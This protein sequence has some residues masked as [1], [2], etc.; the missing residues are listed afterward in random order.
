M[1]DARVLNAQGI[2]YFKNWLETSAG[3]LPPPALLGSDDYMLNCIQ[4]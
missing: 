2:E 1:I 4:I 3:G